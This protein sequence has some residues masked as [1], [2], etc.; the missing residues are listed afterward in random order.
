MISILYIELCLIVFLTGYTLLLSTSISRVKT[1]A[2]SGEALASRYAVLQVY[3]KMMYHASFGFAVCSCG[4][5]VGMFVLSN[6]SHKVQGICV[7]FIF[8]IAASFG[9]VHSC[10]SVWNKFTYIW[11][12]CILLLWFGLGV[13]VFFFFVDYLPFQVALFCPGVILGAVKLCN[14]MRHSHKGNCHSRMN[15]SVALWFLFCLSSEGSCLMLRF[16][17]AK[18]IWVWLIVS[19]IVFIVFFPIVLVHDARVDTARWKRVGKI[20]SKAIYDNT[21]YSSEMCSAKKLK[22]QASLLKW[23]R[24]PI[25]DLEMGNVRASAPSTDSPRRMYNSNKFFLDFSVLAL[26]HPLRSWGKEVVMTEGTL[27]GSKE[28]MVTLFS[29]AR[30]QKMITEDA[31]GLTALKA[32]MQLYESLRDPLVLEVLGVCI[33]PPHLMLVTEKCARGP[34]TVSLARD[35]VQWTHERKLAACAEMC[36]ALAHTHCM[37]VIHGSLSTHCFLVTEEWR[38]KLA[39]IRVPFLHTSEKSLPPLLLRPYAMT[40]RSKQA[41]ENCSLQDD[42][43]CLGRALLEVWTGGKIHCGETCSWPG[44]EDVL[45]SLDGGDEK[46][47]NDRHCYNSGTICDGVLIQWL[48]STADPSCVDASFDWSTVDFMSRFCSGGHIQHRRACR[49][50]LMAVEMGNFLCH[51]HGSLRELILVCLCGC[52]QEGLVC[53]KDSSQHT[54]AG[55][56]RVLSADLSLTSQP[57]PSLTESTPDT[58]TP[59]IA[60]PPVEASHLQLCEPPASL[61]RLQ[62]RHLTSE[63]VVSSESPSLRGTIA[64]KE[65]SIAFGLDDF[66]PSSVDDID[67]LSEGGKGGSGTFSMMRVLRE[68]SLSLP[69]STSH[70][71]KTLSR[72]QHKRCDHNYAKKDNLSKDH[73]RH[74]DGNH[75][76]V[77]EC[78]RSCVTQQKR[79]ENA[80]FTPSATSLT[81]YA[82]NPL[83]MRSPLHV[84]ESEMMI[85]PDHL[86]V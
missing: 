3:E 60:I 80:S 78:G 65:E 1:R 83:F 66:Y 67:G 25:S 52:F 47:C 37:G 26:R 19:Q 64:A 2:E 14:A 84:P 17:T 58:E 27:R 34:L 49:S 30:A 24:R 11:V 45:T 61:M 72:G 53:C 71:A 46:Q 18:V 9:P 10:F 55:R 50:S 31:Y 76:D 69:S 75:S 7:N 35:H 38:L 43:K 63:H 77:R 15:N 22:W 59:A 51:L 48:L 86:N 39:G 21:V 70:A 73:Y 62:Y 33:A 56:V 54:A 32:E 42:V 79:F 20:S 12:A 74:T 85:I 44:L 23:V 28:V 13:I 36:R 29:G 68:G 40:D 57:H 81:K 6:N 82:S 5:V 8:M 16:D 41:A 4:V